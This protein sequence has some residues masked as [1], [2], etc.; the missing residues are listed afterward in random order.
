MKM[1][2][3]DVEKVKYFLHDVQDALQAF[4]RKLC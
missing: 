4:E 3:L 1:N 2:M